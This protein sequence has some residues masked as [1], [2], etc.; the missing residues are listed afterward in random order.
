MRMGVQLSGAAGFREFNA[1]D[2]RIAIK[3]LTVV[4]WESMQALRDRG[5]GIYACMSLQM[6][7]VLVIS[8][9]RNS[10]LVFFHLLD[11]GLLGAVTHKFL[12]PVLQVDCERASDR[13]SC[14]EI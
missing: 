8:S 3:L 10:G 13:L 12:Q 5:P 6:C 4:I 1:M 7:R 11:P 9:R 2:P 14:G